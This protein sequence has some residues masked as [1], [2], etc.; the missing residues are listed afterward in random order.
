MAAY[1]PRNV[2][3]IGVTYATSTFGADHTIGAT[4]FEQNLDP[5]SKEGQVEASVL[6]QVRAAIADN[7]MCFFPFV[8]LI[9]NLEN[10]ADMMA[11]SIGGEWDEN[12]VLNIGKET[13][14]MEIAFNKAAGFTPEDDR[15]PE[16]FYTD[17]SP[18]TGAV[19]DLTDEE[20]ATTHKSL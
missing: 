11:G 17:K 3:G 16:F 12:K 4:I 10:V 1:D 18:A 14:K 7:M 9:E 5:I 13:L 19:F 15:L 6:N 8:A 2:K 20:I